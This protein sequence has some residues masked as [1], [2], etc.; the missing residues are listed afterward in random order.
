MTGRARRV[1]LITGAGRGI[2]RVIALTFAGAGDDLVLAG[3]D[4]AA[5]DAVAAEVRR[6]GVEAL[7]CPTDVRDPGRVA[8]LAS[9]AIERFGDVDVV[10][11]NAGIGG[12]SA[13][14]WEVGL[15]AWDETIA[16]NLTGVFLTCRA[17]L[18]H[19]V[20]RGSGSVVLVGSISGKRPLWGRSAYAASKSALVGLT[21]TL[22]YETGPHGVRVNLVSPGFVTG[23]R[24][25]W[26]MEAQAHGRGIGTEAARAELEAQSPLGR[27]TDAA[28]VAEACLFL[29][30][31]AA[32]GIS[33]A[34][35]DVN[36]VW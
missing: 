24:I 31:D 29:A 32:A 13:P 16:V 19:M 1:T 12:P 28:E 5:L 21:R 23:P 30:S 17:L 11:A 22:A 36:C 8:A 35:L 15:E 14:L 34:D 27:L 18:P 6:G 33:G 10:I 9:A 25:D 20:E 7:V 26:V 4:A 3:R 2:G